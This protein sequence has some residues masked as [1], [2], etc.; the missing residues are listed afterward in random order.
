MTGLYK[1]AEDL[2]DPFWVY[3]M[4]DPFPNYR[5][6]RDEFPVYHN[7]NRDIWALS[8]FEEVQS[9][10]RDWRTFSSADGVDPDNFRDVS[11]PGGF[12][13]MDPPRHDLLRKILQK[14]FNAKTI[15]ALRTSVRTEVETLVDA[16]VER[17]RGDFVQELAWPLP[18]V[19]FLGLMGIP[20]EDRHLLSRWLREV[21]LRVPGNDQLPRA[22]MDA[23]A[24]MRGYL[25]A[26]GEE[27]R[28]KPKDDLLSK[29]VTAEVDGDLLGDEAVGMC[30]LLC[31]AGT[32]TTASLVST[33]LF[34]LERHPDQRSRL[35]SDLSGLPVAIEEILR[36]ESPIHDI[37][38]TATRDIELHGRTIPEGARVMLLYGSANR[39]EREFDEP[40]RLDLTRKIR[41]HLAFG[42]GIHHCIGAP[43]ARLEANIAV[44]TVLTRIPEYQPCGPAERL[45]ATTMRGFTSL[46][47]EF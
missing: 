25:S 24:E 35:A 44:E 39:D 12:V 19:V 38:R 41:R 18:I 23:A 32:E 6:L 34:L 8:R 13:D 17:G 7:E 33:A 29:V 4:D 3:M 42:E 45:R 5:V 27:R 26:L 31:I 28:K 36:Y 11:G 21:Q 20:S 43:L 22:A 47:M 10:A 40:E 16:L 30:T 9:A 46:P 1:I 15:N 14:D 37:A 2:Y